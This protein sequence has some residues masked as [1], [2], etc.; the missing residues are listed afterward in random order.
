MKTL[1]A[2]PT[3]AESLQTLMQAHPIAPIAPIAV[4]LGFL[5]VV[6]LGRETRRA[7]LPF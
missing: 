4:A 5:F 2:D 6:C 1:S 7:F 3:L